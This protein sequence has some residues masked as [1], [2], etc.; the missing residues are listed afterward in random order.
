MSFS[1]REAYWRGLVSEQSSSGESIAAFCRRRDVSQ[2]P[3]YSWRKRFRES[4]AGAFVP[5]SVIGCSELEVQFPCGG[6]MRVPRDHELVR[7]VVGALR[8]RESDA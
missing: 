1:D 3:F 5:V 6:T 4:D 8:D 7:C 2:A